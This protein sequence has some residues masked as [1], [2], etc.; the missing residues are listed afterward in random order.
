MSIQHAAAAFATAAAAFATAAAAAAAGSTPLRSSS[1]KDVLKEAF[2][3]LRSKGK[4]DKSSS[5]K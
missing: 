2:A 1:L 3:G 4:G 5:P